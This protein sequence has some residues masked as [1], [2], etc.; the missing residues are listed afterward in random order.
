[1]LSKEN[2]R[3]LRRQIAAARTYAEAE[4]RVDAFMERVDQKDAK[5]KYELDIQEVSIP[6]L[7]ESM[8]DGGDDNKNLSEAEVTSGLFP[9]AI[10]G[11]ISKQALRALD[12]TMPSTI[13]DQLVRVVPTKMKSEK[14]IRVSSVAMLKRVSEQQDV[15][16]FKVG[17]SYYGYRTFVWARSIS[18]TEE[19]IRFDQTESIWKQASALGKG[20]AISRELLIVEGVTDLQTSGYLTSQLQATDKY[21]YYPSDAGADLFSASVPTGYSGGAAT[22]GNLITSNALEDYTDI[23]AARKQAQSFYDDT[24]ERMLD[25]RAATGKRIFRVGPPVVFAPD[26]LSSTVFQI[27]KSERV[28]TEDASNAANPARDGDGPMR[29][30][31]VYSIWLDDQSESTW[32]YGWPKDTFELRE[33]QPFRLASVDPRG[34]LEMTKKRIYA[35]VQADWWAGM[36][37]MDNRHWIKCTA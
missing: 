32:Y 13:G 7:Y 4:Q 33:V 19:V 16:P 24:Q 20:Y 9:Q 22:T 11:L 28:N 29:F 21:V 8:A 30:Q 31:P 1:M 14:V 35:Y 26:Y 23:R 10:T 2:F 34:S 18:V 25:S 12:E 5:G 36:A 15:E 6:A 27:L 37:A 17:E 3:P